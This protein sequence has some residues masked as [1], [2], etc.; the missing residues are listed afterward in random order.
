VYRKNESFLG[1]SDLPREDV[2]LLS[3]LLARASALHRVALS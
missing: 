3:M 1:D 2:T